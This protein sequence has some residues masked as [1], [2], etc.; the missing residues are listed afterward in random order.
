[1]QRR[2]IMQS[3]PLNRKFFFFLSRYMP[4]SYY[5]LNIVKASIYLAIRSPNADTKM[6]YYNNNRIPQKSLSMAF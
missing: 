3:F 6:H 2:Q 1:M 5:I 4:A